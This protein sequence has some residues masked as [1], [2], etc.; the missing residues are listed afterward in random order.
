VKEREVK[1]RERRERGRER[2]RERGERER[3]ERERLLRGMPDD[4][5]KATHVWLREMRLNLP[6]GAFRGRLYGPLRSLHLMLW[7]K[8]EGFSFG[9]RISE[10]SLA[11]A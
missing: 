8:T 3:G 9:A 11:R 7:I 6:P 1:E 10:Y 4:C 5:M 2:E